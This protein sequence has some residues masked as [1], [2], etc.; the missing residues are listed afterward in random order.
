MCKDKNNVCL[1]VAVNEMNEASVRCT[2]YP[3]LR[4]SRVSIEGPS[5]LASTHPWLL[6]RGGSWLLH[7][8]G[9]RREGIMPRYKRS[10]HKLLHID[11]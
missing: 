7:W 8:G 6:A 5:A 1:Y 2:I 9:C 10:F 11:S 4:Q 3:R